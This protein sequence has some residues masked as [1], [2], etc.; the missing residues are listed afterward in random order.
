MTTARV[1]TFPKPSASLP[2]VSSHRTGEPVSPFR[3]LMAR[4]PLTPAQLSHRR[5]MLLNQARHETRETRLLR[6]AR[7]VIDC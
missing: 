7:F 6:F 4:R 5:R 3:H 2:G 1:L